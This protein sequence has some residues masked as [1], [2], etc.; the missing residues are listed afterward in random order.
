MKLPRQITPPY[1]H[2]DQEVVTNEFW[3]E[4][5]D[6]AF[7]LAG[8]VHMMGSI[9][10]I[11][12]DTECARMRRQALDDGADEEYCDILNKVYMA[13]YHEGMAAVKTAKIDPPGHF[14]TAKN[15]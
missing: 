6:S 2:A 1:R 12:A 7:S 13:F 11:T 14:T 5:R 8:V 4:I 15:S 10:G 3:N 9:A